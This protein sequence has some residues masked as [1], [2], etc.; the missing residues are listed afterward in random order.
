MNDENDYK[1]IYKMKLAMALIK[2]GYKPVTTMPN[3]NNPKF[4]T[5]VFDKTENFMKDFEALKIINCENGLL[6]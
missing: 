1:I 5:W 4:M 2:K 3:P 6:N